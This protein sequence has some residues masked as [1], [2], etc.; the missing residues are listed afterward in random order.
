MFDM[1]YFRRIREAA[2]SGSIYLLL[3]RGPKRRKNT[4]KTFLSV[5]DRVPTGA[6]DLKDAKVM[7]VYPGSTKTGEVR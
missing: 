3:P 2:K 1:S 7:R 6:I 5:L 4:I